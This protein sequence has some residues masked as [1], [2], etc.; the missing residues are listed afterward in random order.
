[1]GFPAAVDFI[2][3]ATAVITDIQEMLD[4]SIRSYDLF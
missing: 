2:R 4:Q 1:M 3:G